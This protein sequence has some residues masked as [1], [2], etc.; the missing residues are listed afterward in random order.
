MTQI[1][2]RCVLFFSKGDEESFFNWALSIPSVT[3]VHGELDEIV[4]SLE[5]PAPPDQC[6]RELIGLL[7]RY[8]V[9]M[10]QLARFRTAGNAAWFDNPDMFWH[11]SVFGAAGDG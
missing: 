8:R 6:L 11:A 5:T 4:I 9:P 3:K 10:A 2:C 7:H 1:R